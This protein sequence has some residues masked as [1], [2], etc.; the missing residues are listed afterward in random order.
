MPKEEEL[1]INLNDN[2]KNIGEL[3]EAV[4]NLLR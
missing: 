1:L 3:E 2:L 4:K